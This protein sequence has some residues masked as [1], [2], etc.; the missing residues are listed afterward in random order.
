MGEGKYRYRWG[1]GK[2]EPLCVGLELEVSVR[3]HVCE[4]VRVCVYLLPLSIE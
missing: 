1:K 2:K 3:T 4:S